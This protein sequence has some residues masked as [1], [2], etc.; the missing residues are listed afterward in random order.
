M[1]GNEL[2]IVVKLVDQASSELKGMSDK[3]DDF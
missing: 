3:L 1:D 2:N